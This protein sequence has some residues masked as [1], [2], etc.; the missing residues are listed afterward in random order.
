MNRIVLC[1]FFKGFISRSQR[2][3]EHAYGWMEGETRCF[4]CFRGHPC[5]P[6]CVYFA[7][8]VACVVHCSV[9]CPVGGVRFL[10]ARDHHD[11]RRCKAKET[12]CIPLVRACISYVPLH[13]VLLFLSF[14]PRSR[15]FLVGMPFMCASPAKLPSDANL[16]PNSRMYRMLYLA[17]SKFPSGHA[18]P[19]SRCITSASG[20]SLS[21]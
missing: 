10:A 5:V 3:A 9:G 11:E 19:H 15:R 12:T 16:N 6:S 4:V 2:D 14:A 1:L 7:C 20:C 8:L 17:T 13:L 18:S 21:A